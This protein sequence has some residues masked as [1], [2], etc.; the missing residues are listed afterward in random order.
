MPALLTRTSDAETPSNDLMGKSSMRLSTIS[1]WETINTGLPFEI[2]R[3]KN[4]CGDYSPNEPQD[5]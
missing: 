1:A 2:A 3:I 4:F 5:V